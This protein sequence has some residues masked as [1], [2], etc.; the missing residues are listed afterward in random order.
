VKWRRANTNTVCVEMV[1]FVDDD[2]RQTVTKRANS[3]NLTL[4]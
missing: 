2:R 3:I 1:R 4:R